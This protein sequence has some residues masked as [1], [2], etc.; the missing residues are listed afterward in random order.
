MFERCLVMLISHAVSLTSLQQLSSKGISEINHQVFF[1]VP[2]LK[3]KSLDLKLEIYR[4]FVI[5][6]GFSI[7]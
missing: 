1:M 5:V 6:G 4:I 7:L 2:L 3:V